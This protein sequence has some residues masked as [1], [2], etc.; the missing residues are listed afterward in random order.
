MIKI[1]LKINKQTIPIKIAKNYLAKIKGLMFKRKINYGLIIP[2]C[3]GVH[4]YFM[5]DNIDIIF[6]NDKN[7]VLYIFQNM[8]KNKIISV[9]E[10]IKNENMSPKRTFK[11]YED[12]KKTSVLEL[13]KNTS[14]N[15]KIGDVLTFEFKDI[16]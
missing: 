9:N 6:F 4:T 13:P 3:I 5:K 11:V 12:I 1:F 10:D 14:K 8:G 15:L 16:I 2:N 7:A